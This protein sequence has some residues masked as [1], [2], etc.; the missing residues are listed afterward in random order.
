MAVDTSIYGQIRPFRMRDPIEARA[1]ALAVQQAEQNN[2]LNALKAQY[3][4]DDRANALADEDAMRAYYQAGGGTQNLNALNARPRLRAAEEKRLLEVEKERAGLGKTQ[5][6]TRGIQQ[7]SQ[8]EQLT[9]SAQ[10][11][12]S[13]NDQAS[14]SQLRQIITNE[15]GPEVA[16]QFPEQFDPRVRDAFLSA[17]LKESDR[18]QNETTRL[19]DAMTDER[20]RAEGA[21]N[22]AVQ[23]RGQNLADARAREMADAQRAQ[24]KAPPGYRFTPEGN[25]EAIPG[26]PADI[27]AGAEGAKAERRQAATAAAAQNVLGAV[28]EAQKLVGMTT[29]GVPGQ[30]LSRVGGTR[31]RDLQSQLE[32]I[33]GNL[34]FDRL[35]EMRDNS[36][37]GG[38]LGQVAVQE[39]MALQST[40]ASLDQ[41]QSDE[42]LRRNLDKIRRHYTRWL[43]VVQ[44]A[45]KPPRQEQ[46]P[47]S[48]G[49]TVLGTE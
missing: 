44:Q 18:L 22:R 12:R 25:L 3:L 43:D 9:R 13:A 4:Q 46:R 7:K 34:G 26:G 31:A 24:S 38:A 23:V 47:S 36:P 29:T 27:K 2:A 45:S 8:I 40:V 39:L 49:W 1:N 20:T 10:M 41:A 48:G 32:T 35:Q 15:A 21:A 28:D 11:L 33:K 17:T 16:A 14:W 37:T 42:Q 30:V 19:R 5:A 6:E